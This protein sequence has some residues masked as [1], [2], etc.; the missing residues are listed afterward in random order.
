M[1][2]GDGDLKVSLQDYVDQIGAESV[3]FFGFQNRD[4]IVKYYTISDLL[5]LPSVR[6]TWG[7]VV[8]EAMC[9]GLPVIVSDQ[10]GAGMDLVSDG[11]NGYRVSTDGDALFR[12]IK[13]MADL[14][15]EERG[16]MGMKS[17]DIVKKWSTR[18]LGESLVEHIKFIRAQRHAPG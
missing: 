16:L 18:N 11:L 15:E 2:V 3:R 12:S 10:V 4:Q 14:S 7:I 5:V 6:E 17:V 9:F 1:I 13:K 8:N